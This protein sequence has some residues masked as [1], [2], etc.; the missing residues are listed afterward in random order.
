[1]ARAKSRTVFLVNLGCLVNESPTEDEQRRMHFP[2]GMGR[3]LAK[4]LV[5]IETYRTALKKVARK[6]GA[7]IIDIE[8]LFSTAESRKVF[9]DSVH[10]NAEGAEMVAARV[11]ETVLPHIR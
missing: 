4:Y 10:F 9:N 5:L 2:R 3:R 6:T 7:T 1:M 11:A 8:S